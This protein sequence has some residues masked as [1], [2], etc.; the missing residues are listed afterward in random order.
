MSAYPISVEQGNKCTLTTM[1]DKTQY[2][3]IF[4]GNRTLRIGCRVKYKGILF[5]IDK[6]IRVSSIVRANI[7]GQYAIMEN[8]DMVSF[9]RIGDVVQ[10]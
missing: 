7:H 5:D 1:N 6:K 9:Q 2:L 10:L 4:N 8:G 3:H